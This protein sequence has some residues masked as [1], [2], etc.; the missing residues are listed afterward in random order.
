MTNLKQ[1]FWLFLLCNLVL[2]TVVPLWRESLPMDTQEAMVWGKYCLFGTTKHPP[3]SGWLAYPFWSLFGHWDGAMYLLSQIFVALGVVYIYRLAREFLSETKA[4][5]AALLQFG[6]IY[7]NFS[8]V[9]YNVNVI[10]LALWPVCAFYFWRGYKEN[11]WSD[12]LLFGLFVGLNVLNKYACGV[13]FAAIGLFVLV[14]PQARKILVNIKAY[15]AALVAALVVAPHLWWLWQHDFSTF[16]YLSQRSNGGNITSIWRH[17]IYPL[18]FF[19][20]Q[21]LFAAPMLITYAVFYKRNEKEKFVGA[22]DK[23]Q[24]LLIVGLAPVAIWLMT[25]LLTGSALKSMWG[26]PCLFLAGIMLFYFLPWRIGEKQEKSFII[27]MA[28]W[29]ILFAFAYGLQTL[30]TKSERFHTDCDEM[31]EKFEQIWKAETGDTPLEYV[32]GDIWYSDMVALYGGKEI[33][34]M[35]WME[36]KA[37]PW[38][39]EKDFAQ[40]GA[41]VI[42]TDVNEYARYQVK[43]GEDISEPNRL[44]LTFKNYFGK[45]KEKQIYY[46]FYRTKKEV[47]DEK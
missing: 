28:V 14:N 2:W 46:G 39:D 21:V 44:N 32:G 47:T 24:F 35:I 34:P 25:S 36:P 16:A 17:F 12:W 45:A 37:N 20:A 11:R 27:T 23:T 7:Y 10:S 29:T 41:L 31:A 13:L 22:R 26:F 18:K 8:S 4:V 3:L 40:K 1:K 38:F 42:A 15:V 30:L 9:E 5:L 33:K 43:Y 6:I 19:G